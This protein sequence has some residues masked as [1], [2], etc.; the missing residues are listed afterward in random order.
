MARICGAALALAALSGCCDALLNPQRVDLYALQADL[1]AGGD[2]DLGAPSR[3]YGNV[4]FQPFALNASNSDVFAHARWLAD[5]DVV[6]RLGTSVSMELLSAMHTPL[7]YTADQRTRGLVPAAEVGT[8]P[9]FGDVPAADDLKVGATDDG[10]APVLGAL[11]VFVFAV[12]GCTHPPFHLGGGIPV[13]LPVVVFAR[14]AVTTGFNGDAHVSSF[15][16]SR[17]NPLLP[18]EGTTA[19]S[20]GTGTASAAGSDA[21]GDGAGATV[22]ESPRDEESL[23][24]HGGGGGGAHKGTPWSR[25]LRVMSLNV[26]N[27]NPPRWLWRHPPDRLRQYALRLLQLG[28]VVRKTSSGG[29]ADP[30]PRNNNDSAAGAASIDH[31]GDVATMDIGAGGATTLASTS[32][33]GDD[34]DDGLPAARRLRRRRVCESARAAAPRHSLDLPDIIALQEVRY[35]STLGGWDTEDER[36]PQ[37]PAPSLTARTNGG[38]GGGGDGG[39]ETATSSAG[40]GD[41]SGTPS[42]LAPTPAPP[43]G[44]FRAALGTTKEW[45]TQILA[46]GVSE[47]YATRNAKKWGRIIGSRHFSRSSRTHPVEGGGGGDTSSGTAGEG[48]SA[49]SAAAAAAASGGSAP[50]SPYAGRRNASASDADAVLAAVAAQPH[51]QLAHLAALLP[52]YQFVS[53]PAQLYVDGASYAREPSRDEEGPAI[54]SRHPIVSFDYM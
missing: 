26:W 17:F 11:T 14:V 8:A 32:T 15:S 38:G 24:G 4:L 42:P 34:G 46:Y 1:H 18:L 25:P 3:G 21:D 51:A 41:G 40:G 44:P 9:V 5:A 52:E 33:R 7:I 36:A 29:R 31:S 49:S 45:L 2:G 20:S 28:E 53:T 10:V 16:A 37:W 39:G 19:H 22:G 23:A 43:P 12:R 48:H 50:L 30:L 35:D 54:F 13:P 6:T 27:S 47:A